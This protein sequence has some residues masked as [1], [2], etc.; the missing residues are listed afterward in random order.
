MD[1]GETHT[2]AGRTFWN[3]ELHRRG[4]S[5][6]HRVTVPPALNMCSSNCGRS[7][8]N[9][10]LEADVYTKKYR[11]GI[12]L[13]EWQIRKITHKDIRSHSFVFKIKL[14]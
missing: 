12:P 13:K 8:I 11:P 14:M 9:L 6:T 1:L 5:A 4:Q 10:S 3:T 2:D 7:A